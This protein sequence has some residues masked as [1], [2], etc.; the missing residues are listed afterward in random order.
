MKVV[1]GAQIRMARGFLKWSAKQLAEQAGIGVATVVRMEDYDGLPNAKGS[2]IEAVYEVLQKALK[3][4]GAE[5]T[6]N[7]NHGPGVCLKQPIT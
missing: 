2:N 5:L 7:D 1:T 4:R 3:E 6:Y